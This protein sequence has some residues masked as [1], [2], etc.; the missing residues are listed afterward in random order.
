[1]RAVNIVREATG[2]SEDEARAA[3]KRAGDVKTAIVSTLLDIT[4]DAA[5]E[6]LAS[7]N[8]R[9]RDAIQGGTR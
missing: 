9:V 4:P 3:L 6:Q 8:G 7:A 5:R 1:V 2:I